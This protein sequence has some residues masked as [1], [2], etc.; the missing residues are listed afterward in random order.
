MKIF[1]SILLIVVFLGSIISAEAQDQSQ[2][3][4][5]MEQMK[6]ALRLSDEQ[7]S[8]ISEIITK[9]EKKRIQEE[10]SKPMN[11]KAMLK[12]EKVRLKEMDKE[13]EPL[14]NPEQLKKY[15][16][17]KKERTNQLRSRIKGRKFKE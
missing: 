6:E 9:S 4:R 12:N 10:S 13:I 8:K 1:E 17:Y 14:L 3:G 15:E 5:R 11:K 16:S 2:T 7:A